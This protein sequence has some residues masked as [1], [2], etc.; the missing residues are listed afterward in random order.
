VTLGPGIAPNDLQLLPT[1]PNLGS[2]RIVLK[3]TND[4]FDCDYIL[5]P[6]NKNDREKSVF[7]FYDGTKVKLT[8]LLKAAGIGS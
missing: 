2:L 5:N 3:G 1:N 7:R 4:T 8:D 6:G